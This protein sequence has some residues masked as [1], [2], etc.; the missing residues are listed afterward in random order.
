MSQPAA[1]PAQ[2]TT[3]PATP[4]ETPPAPVEQKPAPEAAAAPAAPAQGDPAKPADAT[5]TPAA[6][7]PKADAPV[8]PETYDLKLPEGS[9][10]DAKALE[11]FSSFA[12]G[13]G[14]TQEQAQ[15]LLDRDIEAASSAIARQQE[16]FQQK[17]QSWTDELKADPAIG[18]QAFDENVALANRAL[19]AFAPPDFV[20]QLSKTGLG[21][22][23][24]LV[25]T[26]VKVGQAM[27]DDKLIRNGAEAPGGELRH[28]DVLYP[29]LKPQTS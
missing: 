28:A 10:L 14:L 21:M 22:H 2:A 26:F 5:Q 3:Q 17:A 20:K 19:A 8:V 23:P 6:E 24:G 27:A 4:T 18:G 29:S 15:A 16:E 12:K 11:S 13:Q 9:S 7:P 1:A 25:R